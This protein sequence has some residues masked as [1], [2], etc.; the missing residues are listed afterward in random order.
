MRHILL[1]TLFGVA[2]HL[3]T[4]VAHGRECAGVSFPEQ[5]ESEGSALKLN[6]LGLR[7]ATFLK[8]DVYVAALYVPETSREADA[9]LDGNAPRELVLHFVRDVGRGDLDKGWDEGFANNA[10]GRLPA[11][12]ERVEAFKCL[13]TD[14]QAGQLMRFVHRPRAGI[15][16]DIGGTVQGTIAGD[17]FARALFSIW[18]GPHPPNADSKAGLPGG[19]CG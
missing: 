15:R 10:K 18:L 11:L 5:V 13:M 14:V 2:A 8:I 12:K 17:D 6:G 16:V 9:I 19:E 4:G 7:Q 3:G 1:C